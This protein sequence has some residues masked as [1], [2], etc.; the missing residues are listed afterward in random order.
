MEKRGLKGELQLVCG[1]RSRGPHLI[2]A[3]IYWKLCANSDSYSH[4]GTNLIVN[5]AF[6][7]SFS[8]VIRTQL[9]CKWRLEVGG[10]NAGK[11]TSNPSGT[12][13]VCTCP[14][15]PPFMRNPG[16]QH[17]KPSSPPITSA[18]V[19]N[20]PVPHV[21]ELISCLPLPRSGSLKS[22]PKQVY[23]TAI[24]CKACAQSFVLTF[25]ASNSNQDSIT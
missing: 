16:R 2:L 5:C 18:T 3:T 11:L 12:G 8:L 25:L 6:L 4:L 7:Y 17:G 20:N 10:V 19:P 23:H 13:T 24:Q 21:I 22:L 1:V 15:S 14:L 9:L